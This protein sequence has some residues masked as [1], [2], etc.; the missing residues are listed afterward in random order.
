MVAGTFRFA[1]ESVVEE[2]AQKIGMNSMDFRL[3]NAAKEG[4]KAAY[5]EATVAID[6][7]DVADAGITL[8]PG[9]S[10]TAAIVTGERT[11]LRYFVD[12]ILDVASVAMRES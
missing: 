8:L 12:P 11:V 4:T 3:K 6:R 2:L 10:A 7:T 5:Y 1:V 9:M